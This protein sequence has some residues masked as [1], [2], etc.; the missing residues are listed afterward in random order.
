MSTVLKRVL[1]IV[2]A[3]VVVVAVGTIVY[4]KFINQAD[5][6]FSQQDVNTR[7]DDCA[8]ATVDSTGGA[9]PAADVSGTW[10]IDCDSEVGYRVNETINGLDTTANGRTKSITGSLSITGTVV[11]EAGFTVDMTTFTSSESR[12]D[13]QFDGRIMEVDEFP[14]AEFTLTEP[15]DFQQIP[16]DAGSV[17]VDATGNLTLHGV[18]K[19]VTFELTATFKNGRIGILGQIPVTFDDYDIE[20]PSFATVTTEDHGLLEFVLVLDR[21]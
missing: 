20:N 9:A 18:T 8:T 10:I 2:V 19:S 17:T 7:L 21:A 15:I 13:G 11:D 3:L 1:I 6:E 5:D 16:T 4:T 12:R 14:T